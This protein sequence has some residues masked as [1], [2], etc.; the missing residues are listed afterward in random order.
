MYEVDDRLRRIAEGTAD[1]LA[2]RGLAF[3][4]D[5]KIEGLAMTL[6]GFL[7]SAAI[8]I[9]AAPTTDLAESGAAS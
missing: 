5:D 4:E 1:D 8:N 9:N 2:S 7:I 3:V 6:Q